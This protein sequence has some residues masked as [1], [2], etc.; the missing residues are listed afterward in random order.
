MRNLLALVLCVFPCLAQAQEVIVV[1]LATDA[2]IVPDEVFFS[3][4][5]REMLPDRFAGIRARPMIVAPQEA[6]QALYEQMLS[7]GAMWITTP[8]CLQVARAPLENW[9]I[10]PEVLAIVP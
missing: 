1:Q 8:E 3:C 4:I 9:G 5:E 6:G 2:G 10:D 7:P